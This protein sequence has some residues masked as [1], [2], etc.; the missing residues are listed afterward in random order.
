MMVAADAAVRAAYGRPAL[1]R[2]F[3]GGSTGGQQA[4]SL[5]QRH[6]GDVDGI[7]AS[8][9]AHR[10]TP[11]HAYF[12]WNWQATHRRDGSPLF[13]R[14]QEESY[15]A[16]V[17]GLLSG[18]DAFPHA[19]GRFLSDVRWDAALRAEAVRRAAARDPSLTPEHLDALRRLQDGPVHART[20]ERLFD[21]LPPASEFE[22]ACGNLYL[23]QWVFGADV[24]FARLD[25]DRDI[26]RYF[27][28]LSP[29]LDAE[30][31][32]LAPFRGRGGKL[33]AIAGTADSCV[34][35]SATIDYYERVVA[36]F[37][38]DLAAVQSFFLLYLLPGRRHS[39][40]PGVQSLRGDFSLLSDW[41]EKGR[42]P[43]AEGVACVPPA[44]RVPLHPYPA[45]TAPDGGAA[46]YRR[47]G[48]AP[49]PSPVAGQ[50]NS[51]E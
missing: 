25:F 39:G 28:A 2:Y 4:F 45:T 48:V 16:A 22:P 7:L 27:A 13:T 18:D 29:D 46:P 38:G 30:D 32:D 51:R 1:F 36:R 43:R 21:G 37:G 11:L 3:V 41:L 35:C 23:F 17:L 34:P 20:G 44:F 42:R 9:P 33:L 47:G 31:P 24:D 19:R 26:D 12:L 50:R 40:G 49:L 15:R 10:R 5:A 8:V 6:P 14:A